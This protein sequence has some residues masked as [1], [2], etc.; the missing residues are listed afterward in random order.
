LIR[1]KRRFSFN[2]RLDRAVLSNHH[3]SIVSNEK[4]LILKRC[5]SNIA[6]N[7]NEYDLDGTTKLYKPSTAKQETHVSDELKG[8]QSVETFDTIP[9]SAPTLAG[10]EK[11]W[12]VQFFF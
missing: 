1:K 8:E 9:K 6:N 5:L 7:K 2:F 10:V 4:L 3:P 12:L 11:V